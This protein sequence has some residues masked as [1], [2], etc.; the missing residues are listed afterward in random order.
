V[1]L[2]IL[3]FIM[4]IKDLMAR[5]PEWADSEVVR[6]RRGWLILDRPE[7]RAED[8]GPIR[9]E[10]VVRALR[11]GPGG[12][13][14]YRQ[15]REQLRQDLQLSYAQPKSGHWRIVRGLRAAGRLG[16][17]RWETGAVPVVYELTAAGWAA[18]GARVGGVE[19]PE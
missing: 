17:V 1:W 11:C 7:K 16:W 15:V 3:F 12:A 5:H 6:R 9:A 8:V 14:T 10:D 2:G 13:M 19:L 4:K 18:A